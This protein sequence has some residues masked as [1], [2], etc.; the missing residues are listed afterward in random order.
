MLSLSSIVQVLVNDS[1][2]LNN[3]SAFSTGLILA[4]R[5]MFIFAYSSIL[6]PYFSF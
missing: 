2:A 6:N 5:S 4:E 3:T 1:A